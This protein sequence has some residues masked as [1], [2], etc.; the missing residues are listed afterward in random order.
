MSWVPSAFGTSAGS[1]RVDG[2]NVHGAGWVRLDSWD[3]SRIS[4]ED[5]DP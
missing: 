4:H 2:A 5:D 1:V 3:P